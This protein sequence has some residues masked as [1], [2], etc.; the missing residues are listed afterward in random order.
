MPTTLTFPLYPNKLIF[1][2]AFT[3]VG[4]SKLET[5]QS[6]I[7]DNDKAF[8]FAFLN[9][10]YIISSE[11]LL[12]SIYR[13]VSSYEQ[14]TNRTKSIN[15]EIIYNL[16]P[17]NNIME[18]LNKF[19][20]DSSKHHDNLLCVKV[21][22]IGSSIKPDDL[23]QHLLDFLEVLSTENPQFNDEFLFNNVDI[24]KFKKLY[25]LNDAKF[26]DTLNHILQ[27]RLSRLAIGT[28]L[29]RGV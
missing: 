20:V 11:H 2:S 5:I 14:G 7:I 21:L 23:N 19:G 6:K 9:C 27:Q 26:D 4:K 12:H 24:S 16:C 28:C 17:T 13:A 18:A 3:N 1:I 15:T 25:K 29:L 10:N 22:D 8:D